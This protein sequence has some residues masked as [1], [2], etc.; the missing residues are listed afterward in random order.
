VTLYKI[1]KILNGEALDEMIEALITEDQA[2]RL[3]E[4]A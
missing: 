1:D 4:I 2:E 3:A